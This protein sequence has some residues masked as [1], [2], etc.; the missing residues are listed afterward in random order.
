[1]NFLN[2]YNLSK[3]ILNQED[4]EKKNDYKISL[5]K[6]YIMCYIGKYY[7]AYKIYKQISENALK[8]KEF[9][10]YSISEFNRYILTS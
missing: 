6:A 7:D 1:M 10:I 8:N 4:S 2:F 5:E 9:Y 3:F